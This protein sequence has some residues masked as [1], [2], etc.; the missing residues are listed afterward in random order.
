[1]AKKKS[2]KVWGYVYSPTATTAQKNTIS[3][4][5]EPLIEELKKNLEP[6]PN[7]RNLIIVLMFLANG[8]AIFSILCKSLKLVKI[9]QRIFLTLV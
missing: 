4:Q 8:G 7:H 3:T 1:M 9:A 2:K 6:I 5:F